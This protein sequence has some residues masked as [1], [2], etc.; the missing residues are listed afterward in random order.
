MGARRPWAWPLVPLYAAVIG[1][2]N[3]LR[4]AGL[5]KVRRLK[6]PV[7]SVGS[8]SAGGA[9]KTPVVIALAK[10]LRARGWDVDVLS[11]GYGRTGQD[12]EWVAALGENAAERY[13]D[14]PVVIARATGVPVWV[15]GNRFEA[16][17]AAENGVGGHAGRPNGHND[18]NGNDAGE[19]PPGAKAVHLLDD[20]FQ[21]RQLARNF[22]VVL[23][24]AEDLDD[25]LMPAGNLREG[26]GAL[27]RA[28]AVV[29]R[30]DELEDV[31]ERAWKLMREGA[32]MWLVRRKLVFPAPLLVFTAGL[33][34][35]AFCA[36]ARPEGFQAM[37]TEA[38]CGV[39]ETIAFPDHHA[40]AMGDMER[41]LEVGRRL[42]ATGFVTTEKDN[43][44]L[45]KAMCDRLETLGPVMVVGLEAEFADSDAVVN[46]L[47]AR[48][49]VGSGE[50]RA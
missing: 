45:T 12:V 14:E 34:P 11:R 20:G 46:A 17:H 5:L 7:V 3:A 37:L 19:A 10:M 50:Q 30:E 22:D 9:G 21:H 41:I 29:V 47:E 36:V 23:V 48:L 8:I 18:L 24:T 25:T 49:G 15:S 27:R 32:Q 2:K 42:G 43:V 35:V 31:K 38:G 1:V 40:Y 13:G 16:G 44:K 26:F 28:D 4:S 39:V 33:R 6:R